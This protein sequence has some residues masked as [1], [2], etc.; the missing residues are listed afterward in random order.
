LLICIST[1]P[2]G[3][4]DGSRLTTGA[5]IGPAA[6]RPGRLSCREGPR[7]TRVAW[8]CD[9]A[10]RGPGPARFLGRPSLPV[11]G[12]SR[13]PPGRSQIGEGGMAGLYSGP[14]MSDS[15]GQVALK[16]LA[17][18]LAADEGIPAPLHP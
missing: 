16:I 13:V 7:R 14:G 17:P 3:N 5:A 2:I 6:R 9:G 11:R 1:S 8:R 10:M 12:Y 18:T 15:S 4:P